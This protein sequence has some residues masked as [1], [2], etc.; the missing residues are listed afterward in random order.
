[1]AS[2]KPIR[3]SLDVARVPY[4][5]YKLPGDSRQWVQVCHERRAVV[6]ELATHANAD[7]SS[8]Y[9]SVDTMAAHIG[10]SPR[11]FR[12]RLDELVTLGFL[13]N[14]T[15]RGVKGGRNRKLNIQ[16]IVKAGE[17]LQDS[18]KTLQN[19]GAKPCKTED[20]PCES[21]NETL[22]ESQLN[23]AKVAANPATYSLQPTALQ[24]AQQTA[25]PTE[26]LAWKGFV[27]K[28][29]N[30]PAEMDG[31]TEGKLLPDLEAVLNALGERV[32]SE[33]IWLWRNN[34]T[35]PLEGYRGNRWKL[36]L[37]EALK[38]K[39]IAQAKENAKREKSSQQKWWEENTAEGRADAQQRADGQ[40]AAAEAFMR[41]IHAE[42]FG[43]GHGDDENSIEETCRFIRETTK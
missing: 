10:I 15:Q 39:L 41:K 42:Q 43:T 18:R 17:T 24:T 5:A 1:V 2:D 19:S 20:K 22:Q 8:I 25:H 29:G 13:L 12:S 16:A 30:C 40:V 6:A 11:T 34:R 37:D 35:M 28:P 36:F 33:L 14:G 3:A 21:G 9:A 38:E 26:R 23:P 7:G 32:T 27:G 31:S 4:Q